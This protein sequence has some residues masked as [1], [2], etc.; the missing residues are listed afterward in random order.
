MAVFRPVL[1]LAQ[2]LPTLVYLA[3]LALVFLI[4][5]AAA[6]IA[7]LIYSVPIC[8]RITSHAR[9]RACEPGRSRRPTR[10]APRKWQLLRKVQLPMAKQTI[11]LGV[12]QTTLAALSFVVI[13]ALIG[14]PGPRQAGRATR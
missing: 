6:T 8:I 10:W 1:D 5:I 12:N 7:T 13:A 11:I 14:A 4:G 3:P 9:A 2:I